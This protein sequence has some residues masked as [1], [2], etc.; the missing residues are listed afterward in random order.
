MSAQV[1]VLALA[2]KAGIAND[3]TINVVFSAKTAQ[4]MMRVLTNVEVQTRDGDQWLFWQWRREGST[5]W[6]T[7]DCGFGGQLVND[8]FIAELH[9]LAGGAA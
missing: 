2:A 9:A 7:S 6:G 1:D 8:D 5:P 4:P 3:Q